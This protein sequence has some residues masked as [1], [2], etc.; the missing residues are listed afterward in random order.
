[1]SI[2][3]VPGQGPPDAKGMIVGEAPGFE[4]KKQLAPFVGNSGQFLFT[5]LT[6]LSLRR[7][8][9][10]VTNVVKDV[11][12]DSAG[13]IRKPN[14]RE[15]LAW[16]PLLAYEIETHA[17]A[18][19]LCLG[20]T[21]VDQLMTP[22]TAFGNQEGTFFSAW[23]PAH[24]LYEENPERDNEKMLEWIQQLRPFAEAVQD[25]QAI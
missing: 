13:R 12:V 25:A 15:I 24:L 1:M 19:V 3:Y 16:S 9:L 20:R 2:L 18:A 4:E 22:G 14:E 11:P 5:I 21:A 6:G 7:E 10:Y 8:D 17:P 23:H